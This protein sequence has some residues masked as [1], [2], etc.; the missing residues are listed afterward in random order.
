MSLRLIIRDEAEA[1]ITT[2]ALWYDEQR[3]GLGFQFVLEVDRAIKRVL[4]SPRA[5]RLM[6][7]KPEVRR[8]LTGR[9]PYRVFYLL[10]PDTIVVFAVLHGARQDSHWTG[11][12]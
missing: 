8:V 4:A 6:R 1:D 3:P 12:V 7:R 9:F 10:R 5:S 11:R 2:S